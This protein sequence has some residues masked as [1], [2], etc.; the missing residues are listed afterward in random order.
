MEVKRQYGIDLLRILSMFMIIVLH[1]LMQGGIFKAVKPL[2]HQ[3][4]V[5]WMLEALCICAVNCYALI[6]GYVSVNGTKLKLHKIAVLWLQVVFYTILFTAV[7][8]AL[9]FGGEGYTYEIWKKSIFPVFTNHYWYFSCYFALFFFIPF[10][11]KMINALREKELKMLFLIIV[12]VIS[13]LPTVFRTDVFKISKGYSVIWL[14]MLYILGGITK[15]LHTVKLKVLPLLAG[16]AACAAVAFVF[17]YAVNKT[18]TDK[19]S[20]QLL[21]SYSAPTILLAAYFLFL[22]AINMDIK[23]KPAVFLIR[24]FSPLSFSVYIIHTNYWIWNFVMKNR[25][26]DYAKL[27]SIKLAAAVLL[28]A[29]AIYFFC[30]AIDAVRLYIFKVTRLSS[31]LE[32][33]ENKI[34]KRQNT[35]NEVRLPEKTK[36]S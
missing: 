31:L 3:F 4:D 34:F 15:R 21:Y 8:G 18:G 35:K 7:F 27:R 20:D 16:Y 14:M 36:S 33:L 12:V 19:V 17:L 10:L 22:A 25:F 13:V 29:F 5:A 32:R 28:T 9:K 30:S 24:W 26:A 23:F 6:S 1:I 2:S 11:N